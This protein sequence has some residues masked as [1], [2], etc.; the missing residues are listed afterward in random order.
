M[1][2]SNGS[3][4]LFPVRPP[5]LC[6]VVLFAAL[7]ALI[8]RTPVSAQR[9]PGTVNLG[10]QVG[11]P[12]GISGKWYRPDDTAYAGLVTTDGDDFVTMYVH[13]LQ[14]RPLPD[15]LLHLYA[16]PGLFIGGTA[17]DEET[18]RATLG[19]SIQA[20]LNFY[21]ERFEVFLHVTPTVRFLPSPK[22]RL[23]GS[24]GLRYVLWRP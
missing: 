2:R 3:H 9:M 19:V 11:Q 17:L 22:P 21:A 16:G 20:G 24:V 4:D 13:R 18:P 1:P 14:E 6:V 8:A 23:G 12:A 7:T 5:P 15:S 10:P